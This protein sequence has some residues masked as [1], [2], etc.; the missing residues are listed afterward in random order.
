MR[1]TSCLNGFWDFSHA[2]DHLDAVPAEW[3]T[4]KIQVPSPF[5][6]N[7]FSHGYPRTTAGE[8]YTVMGGDFR[9]YPE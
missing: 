3:D 2:A 6:I 5:N 4:V 9:L 7:S 1:K 8:T